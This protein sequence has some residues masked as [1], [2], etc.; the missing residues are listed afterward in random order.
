M[1]RKMVA[2]VM[3]AA[4]MFS[5]VACGEEGEKDAG[6][7]AS[8]GTDTEEESE[9]TDGEAAAETGGEV[10]EIEFW[11]PG[12]EGETAEES[13]RVRN[14]EA[15][16]EEYAGQIQVNLVQIGNDNAE[17]EQKYQ[18]AASAGNLPDLMIMN[19]GREFEKYIDAGHFANM[20]D[21]LNNEEFTSKFPEDALT[22]QG[23]GRYSETT[24]YGV[25]VGCDVQGWFY[26]TALFEQCGLEIPGTYDE[27]LECVAVFKE[28][29]IVPIMHGGLEQFPLWG[30]WPWFSS[31]GF[32][33]EA[34]QWNDIADGSMKAADCEGLR[35]TFEYIQQLQEAGAYPENVANLNNTQAMETFMAGGAAMYCGGSWMG[36]DM[37]KSEI[38]EDIVFDFGPQFEDSIYDQTVAMRP[39]SWTFAFGSRLDE[40]EAKKEAAATFVEWWFSEE[41]ALE[42]LETE[43]EAP[44]IILSDESVLDQLGPVSAQIAKC[45]VADDVVSVI[46]PNSW[47]EYDGSVTVIW[48]AM[49]SIITGTIDAEE[50]LSQI[51]DWADRL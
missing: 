7:G 25:P 4:M 40:D 51:Q 29:D 18:M 48:N 14:V 46:D 37:D 27:L 30:Y 13:A 22:L 31:L 21:Y 41:V 28:N 1:K 26:N 23:N 16:N 15:F 44:A 33:Q 17:L 9:G 32:T 3:V 49:T 34:N 47:C 12:N 45:A 42:N 38:A 20:S 10:I 24:M 35:K 5:A 2:L 8:G 50:A 19:C 43:G 6:T 36:T 39:Y 11:N